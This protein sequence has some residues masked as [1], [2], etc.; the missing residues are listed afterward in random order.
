MQQLSISQLVV[1]RFLAVVS[2]AIFVSPLFAQEKTRQL[3]MLNSAQ[4][5]SKEDF[6]KE[7]R[8]C[9][10]HPISNAQ[11]VN[12]MRR[13]GRFAAANRVPL[14]ERTGPITIPVFFHV[15]HNDG[16]GNVSDQG[17]KD[18]LKVLNDAFAPHDI[19][20]VMSAVDRTDNA[21]WFGMDLDTD[22]EKE[23]KEALGKNTNRMLNFYT[24]SPPGGTLGWATFP[25]ELA[26]SPGI[27]GV[28]MLHSTLPGGSSTPY[29]LGDTAV[30]E[31]GHWLGLLHTFGENPFDPCLD[32]DEVGDTPAHHVNFGTPPEGTDTCPDK[33]GTDPIRN[34]MNY[35]DDD[36]MDRFSAQQVERL[37]EHIALFRPLLLGGELRSKLLYNGFK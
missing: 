1:C 24:C 34:Y 8:R 28:V 29:N 15:I 9:G 37:H 35:V 18:Q 12:L 21:T 6:V 27:D 14:D 3:F 25:W 16:V 7:G 10:T 26:A 33:P 30:H 2:I 32:T 11:R 31:V 20:F 19:K 36:H 17:L 4:F 5:E 23:A 13:V 22:A